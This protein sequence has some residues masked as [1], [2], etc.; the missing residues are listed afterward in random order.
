MKRPTGIT[1]IA[2]VNVLFA[3]IALGR[4]LPEFREDREWLAIA[5]LL[6]L[7]NIVCTAAFL[8]LK[9]WA[10]RVFI[11]SAGLGLLRIS[12]YVAHMDGGDAI[13]F[14]AEKIHLI[15][16]VWALGSFFLRSVGALL[17]IP[18]TRKN[19]F[20]KT[21]HSDFQAF[22]LELATLRTQGR[23]CYCLCLQCTNVGLFSP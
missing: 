11:A 17:S 19:C 18:T 20:R 9:N 10:R 12:G 4:Y 15:G 1:V 3:G 2:L 13:P 8:K 23:P 5:M 16:I 22:R 21:P 7:V 6:L 14:R